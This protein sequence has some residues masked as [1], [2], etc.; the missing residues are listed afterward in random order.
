[1]IA[2]TCFLIAK[3]AQSTLL[4]VIP[5]PA[6]MVAG[7]GGTFEITRDTKIAGA[8]SL[9]AVKIFQSLL[10]GGAGFKLRQVRGTGPNT[11]EFTKDTAGSIPAEGY[12]L[13]ADA[14]GV[15]IAYSDPG[16]GS[17]RRRDLAAT[18]SASRSRV[19]R[20]RTI[21]AGRCLRWTSPTR[22]D[23]AGAV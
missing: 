5:K 6:S 12:T 3:A 2:L 14:N 11:I 10:D 7:S 20:R 13:H 23:S 9:P 16:G 22:R 21:R 8:D 1:M 15:K 18:A 4:P 19:L 17:V